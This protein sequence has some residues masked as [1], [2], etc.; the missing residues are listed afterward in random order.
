MHPVKKMT[1][2][3]RGGNIRTEKKMVETGKKK[4][5]DDSKGASIKIEEKTAT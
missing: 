3:K 1:I 4:C 2:S 5:G